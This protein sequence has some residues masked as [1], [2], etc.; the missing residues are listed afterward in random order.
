MLNRYL[1][2][3]GYFTFGDISFDLRWILNFFKLNNINNAVSDDII[4]LKNKAQ[5][6]TLLKKLPSKNF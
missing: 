6:A 3:I 5:A 4:D 1:Y 2:L